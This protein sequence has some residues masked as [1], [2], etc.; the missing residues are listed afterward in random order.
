[1][2]AVDADQQNVADLALARAIRCI[3]LA[4]ET[5]QQTS[6]NDNTLQ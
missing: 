1:M 4:L 2:H 6:A 5:H 3:G